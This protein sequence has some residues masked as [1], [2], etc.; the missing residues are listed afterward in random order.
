MNEREKHLK[1]KKRNK[2]KSKKK[3]YGFD[4]HKNSL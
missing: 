3:E 4:L 1:K 2:I